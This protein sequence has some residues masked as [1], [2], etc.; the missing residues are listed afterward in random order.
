MGLE[1]LVFDWDFPN[2][3]RQLRQAIDLNPNY[4][5]AY[6]VYAEYLWCVG[7]Y[8]DSL[9]ESRKALELEPFQSLTRYNLGS[10]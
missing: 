1:L 4:S 9:R 8:D 2:A 6:H 3:E 10:P 7:K 5:L